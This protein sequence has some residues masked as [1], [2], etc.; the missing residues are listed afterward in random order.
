MQLEIK[1]ET[2]ELKRIESKS[3]YNRI[4]HELR[5]PI[6]GMTHLY[7]EY[8]DIQEM[9][10][11]YS[12]GNFDGEKFNALMNGIGDPIPEGKEGWGGIHVTIEL[13]YPELTF[14]LI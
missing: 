4:C 5:K 8:D 3:T 10:V 14:K 2:R 11:D 6:W 1:L 7:E 13:Y 12:I 9:S